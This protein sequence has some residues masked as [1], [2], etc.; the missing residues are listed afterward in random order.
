MINFSPLAAEISSEVWAP[1]QISECFVSWLHYCTDV[2][3]QRSSKLCT[4]FDRLLGWYP[5]YIYF[6][7]LWSPTE[8]CQVQF[9]QVQ[10]WIHFASKS[11][12]PYIGSI[13][14]R[15]SSSGH[16]PNCIVVQG[17]ELRNFRTS[18]ATEGTTYIPRAASTLNI[19]P[20]CSIIYFTHQFLIY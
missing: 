3:Q 4:M 1:Q 20:H 14:A 8:Y 7:T 17:M 6:W 5:I 10:L 15:H 16:E 11:C 2:S 9:C 12:I 19:S 18:F 13:A